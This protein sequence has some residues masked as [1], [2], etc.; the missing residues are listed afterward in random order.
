MPTRVEQVRVK[1]FCTDL[2]LVQ[3]AVWRLLVGGARGAR[4]R[5]PRVP[6]GLESLL[7]ATGSVSTVSPALE[8]SA[9]RGRGSCRAE[10]ATRC[11]RE[12]KTDKQEPGHTEGGG[13]EGEEVGGG[14]GGI[15]RHC[16]RAELAPAGRAWGEG[17]TWTVSLP[18]EYWTFARALSAADLRRRAARDL[19]VVRIGQFGELIDEASSQGT[20]ANGGA[21]PANRDSRDRRGGAPSRFSLGHSHGPGT[22]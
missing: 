19:G 16:L 18:T 13:K 3:L 5:G 21:D 22:G 2:A 9:P 11:D 10:V 4:A 1:L 6:K 8:P 12:N 14:L 15:H 7:A 17:E 20:H